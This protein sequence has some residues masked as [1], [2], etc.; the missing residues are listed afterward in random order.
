VRTSVATTQAA[1][2]EQ[3]GASL[4]SRLAEVILDALVR[5]I[6]DML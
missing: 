1:A 3:G 5:K 4:G 6:A 2:D